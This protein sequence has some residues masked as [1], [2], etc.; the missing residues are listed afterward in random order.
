MRIDGTHLVAE[1]LPLHTKPLAIHTY[2]RP[3]Q[4]HLRNPSDQ[5]RDQ[6]LDCPKTR[7]MLSSSLPDRKRD[8]VILALDELDVHVHMSDVFRE[9]A[10]RALDG[11]Q[12]RLDFELHAL[13]DGELLCGQDVAHLKGEVRLGLWI[14]V[15]L[16]IRVSR[17][18]P[19]V[20]TVFVQYF[21]P[22]QHSNIS[23]SYFCMHL[24]THFERG[25]GLR[26]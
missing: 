12:A 19:T 14:S 16:S 20:S 11:N 2:T 13:G 10:A 6:A 15:D 9:L 24:A 5:V 1:P 21:S 26:S 8:L 7:N 22:E 25:L 4:T 17:V 3:I 18:N 23:L